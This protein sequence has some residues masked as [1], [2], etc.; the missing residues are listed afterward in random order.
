MAGLGPSSSSWADLLPELLVQFVLRAPSYADRVRFRAVC[1]SWRSAVQPRDLPPLLPWI[2]LRDGAFLS[3]PDGVLHRFPFPVDVSNRVSMGDRLC[4]LHLDGTCSL[5][6]PLTGETTREHIDIDPDILW[7]DVRIQAH[8]VG[9][10]VVSDRV[11]AAISM[12]GQASVCS[13]AP[14]TCSPCSR[15]RVSANDMVL[16]QGKLYLLTSQTSPIRLHHKLDVMD[17]CQANN[18]LQCVIPASADIPTLTNTWPIAGYK[19]YYYLVVVSGDRLLMVER[20]VEMEL[21]RSAAPHR[22]RRIE[23]FEATG[24]LGG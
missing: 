19:R 16:F 18:R 1:R 14:Q 11:V 8:N 5:T 12:C 24:L 15:C 17:L 23:V 20:E 22:T 9:K 10:L 13:R 21:L 2:A 6:N 3:L 7:N 4:L